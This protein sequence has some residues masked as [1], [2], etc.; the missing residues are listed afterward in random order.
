MPDAYLSFGPDPSHEEGCR[1]LTADATGIARLRQSQSIEGEWVLSS[2]APSTFETVTF[3]A[4]DQDEA[5]RNSKG[6]VEANAEEVLAWME[7]D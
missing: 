6:W 2:V 7:E 3:A 1:Y 4:V 5:E